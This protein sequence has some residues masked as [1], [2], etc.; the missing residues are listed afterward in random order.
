VPHAIEA[1]EAKKNANHRPLRGS[2]AFERATKD[3][4]ATL[5]RREKGARSRA[6]RCGTSLKEVGVAT[7]FGAR[8]RLLSASS[9]A[10]M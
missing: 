5:A 9:E 3:E 7:V 6:S 8:V 10:T 1:E 4:L 2:P